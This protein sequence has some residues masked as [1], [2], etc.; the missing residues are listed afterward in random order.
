MLSWKIKGPQ[1]AGPYKECFFSNEESRARV[2]TFNTERQF[3]FP[4]DRRYVFDLDVK[5]PGTI[6]ALQF[7]LDHEALEAQTNEA[8]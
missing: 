5:F 7:S 6:V 8:H 2:Q 3:D 1:F 4:P